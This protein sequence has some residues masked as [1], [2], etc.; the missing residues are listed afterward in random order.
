MDGCV[1]DFF[2]LH[3]TWYDDD[4]DDDDDNDDDGIDGIDGIDAFDGIWWYMT[5]YDGDADG[6][7][8]GG[9]DADGDADGLIQYVSFGGVSYDQTCLYRRDLQQFSSIP[10]VMPAAVLVWH[11]ACRKKRT[12]WK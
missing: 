12:I 7:A 11:I 8:D 9:A 5:V 2:P 1:V 3:P 10:P 4:D 6:D